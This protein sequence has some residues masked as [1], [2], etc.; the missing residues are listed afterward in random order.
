MAKLRSTQKID[1]GGWNPFFK[2]FIEI[3]AVEITKTEQ[4]VIYLI[5]DSVI[6]ERNTIGDNGEPIIEEY[7]LHVI[8]EKKFSVPMALWN[9]LYNA[10]EQAMPA[11]LTP[12]ER[13]Q[14]RPKLALKMY[15]Q[16]DKISDENGN[17]F[18]LYGL[19]PNEI[20]IV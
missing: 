5:T 7:V 20:E 3:E 13:D 11:E 6:G 18:C 17:E 8:R 12:F 2:N 9:Q 14:L 19:Q 16:N 10:V 15:F 1:W 4:E